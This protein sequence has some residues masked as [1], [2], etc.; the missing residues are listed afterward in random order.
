[1][2]KEYGREIP[3]S[4]G[5]EPAFVRNAYKDTGFNRAIKITLSSTPGEVTVIN[6]PN[7]AKGFKLIPAG[8]DV[9]FSVDE[10][11]DDLAVSSNLIIN[12]GDFSIGGIAKS[13]LTEVRLLPFKADRKIYL[14][15]AVAD[16]VL[17]LEV[18]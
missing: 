10:A 18:F 3:H 17:E 5:L 14:K 9:L 4:D 13:N 8:E 7:E 12:E 15:S 1:M 6:L 11:V 16:V 2:P